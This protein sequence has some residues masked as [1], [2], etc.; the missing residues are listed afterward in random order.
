MAAATSGDPS[1]F[2]GTDSAPHPTTAKYGPRAA[3]G[4]FN[5]PYGLEVVAEVFFAA[6]ALDRLD[7]FVSAHGAAVY[8]VDPSP[9]RI[10]LTRLDEPVPAAERA[11]HLVTA[12][13]DEVVLFG[14][15]EARRW[16]VEPA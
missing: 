15:D 2:C 12:G 14:V 5:A 4:I 6:D 9:D 10:R 3:A 11:D 1:F 7:G 13:G 16:L 8:G